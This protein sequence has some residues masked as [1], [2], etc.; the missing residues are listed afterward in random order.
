M[1]NDIFSCTYSIPQNAD[2]VSIFK[3][4]KHFCLSMSTHYIDIIDY[5]SPIVSPDVVNGRFFEVKG[6]QNKKAHGHPSR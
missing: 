6:E 4:F 2:K 5:H 1:K 3:A